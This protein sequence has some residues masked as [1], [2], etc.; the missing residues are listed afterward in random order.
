MYSED[1]QM[2]DQIKDDVRLMLGAGK[3]RI[4]L[5]D[6]HLELCVRMAHIPYRK[7]LNK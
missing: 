1:T 2:R 4:E 6:E 3:V 5:S 7:K